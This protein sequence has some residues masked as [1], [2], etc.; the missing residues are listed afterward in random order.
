MHW[1]VPLPLSIGSCQVWT[2]AHVWIESRSNR[3]ACPYMSS[4]AG[5]R[6]QR[7]CVVM[8][9]GRIRL[10]IVHVTLHN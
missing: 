5:T 1:P 3:K 2:L 8:R 4:L 6:E 7:Q 9:K 10:I